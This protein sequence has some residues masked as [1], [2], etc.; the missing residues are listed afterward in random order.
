[1]SAWS[2]LLVGLAVIVLPSRRRGAAT[3]ASP[4][5]AEPGRGPDPALPLVLDLLAAALRAGRPV[6][7]ALD[8]AAGAGRPATAAALA[9]VGRL[10]RLGAEPAAAWGVLDPDDAARPLVP[11]AIR[12]AASGVRLAGAAERLAGEL[13]AERR[14]GSAAR[15]QRAGV[16]AMAPLAA[17]FLPSFVCLGIVPTVVGVARAALGHPP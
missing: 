4:L 8:L 7:D 1:V 11:V 2:W 17:C 15:A 10:L 12:S 5:T 6:A 16:F 9:R 13:R 14:A 3:D